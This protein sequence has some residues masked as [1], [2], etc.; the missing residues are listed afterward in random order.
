MEPRSRT[1]VG[2]EPFLAGLCGLPETSASKLG[3]LDKFLMTS[4]DHSSLRRELQPENN[5]LS[6]A[7]DMPGG[8]VRSRRGPSEVTHRAGGMVMRYPRQP[9]RTGPNRRFRTLLS[10]LIGAIS[11]TSPKIACASARILGVKVRHRGQPFGITVMLVCARATNDN[12]ISTVF[13]L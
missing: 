9:P 8:Y 12:D 6:L 11:F 1:R 4:A 5:W 7:H 3:N 13:R 2:A 10:E